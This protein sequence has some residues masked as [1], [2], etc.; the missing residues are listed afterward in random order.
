VKKLILFLVAVAFYCLAVFAKTVKKDQPAD[1]LSAGT[2]TS[3][4]T[5]Q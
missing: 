2:S 1:K 3:Y 4:K 5:F